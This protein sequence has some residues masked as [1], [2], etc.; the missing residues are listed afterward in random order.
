MDIAAQ[1][2]QVFTRSLWL[3][4]DGRFLWSSTQLQ[5]L[6]IKPQK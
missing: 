3:L 4:F 5:D 6:L 2:P 1:S